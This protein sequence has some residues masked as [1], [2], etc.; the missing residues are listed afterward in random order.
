MNAIQNSDE[1]L[2]NRK[3]VKDIIITYFLTCKKPG[4]KSAKCLNRATLCSLASIN[5]AVALADNVRI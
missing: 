3:L 5:A 1:N 4:N 2:S